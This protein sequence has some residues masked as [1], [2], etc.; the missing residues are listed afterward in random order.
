[1]V[2]A[3][4]LDG[5]AVAV[6]VERSGWPKRGCQTPGASNLIWD[7]VELDLAPQTETATA[8]GSRQK[9]TGP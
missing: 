8:S 1:M 6:R 9:T 5:M 4:A 3:A 7:A 2:I